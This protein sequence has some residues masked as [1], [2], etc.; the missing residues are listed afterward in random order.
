MDTAWYS[1]LQGSTYKKVLEKNVNMDISF[2]YLEISKLKVLNEHNTALLHSNDIVYE[3]D[4]QFRCK[5]CNISYTTD[6]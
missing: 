5:V 6:F 4:P 3:Y 2:N 1:I